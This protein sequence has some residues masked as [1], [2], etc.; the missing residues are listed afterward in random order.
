M[1]FAKIA[2]VICFCL[3][4]KNSSVYHV[5]MALIS[6]KKI[7]LACLRTIAQDAQAISMKI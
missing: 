2:Q 4:F 1:E 6:A 5:Q 3:M 7:T